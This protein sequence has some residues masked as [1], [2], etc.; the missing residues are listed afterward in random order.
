MSPHGYE[1]VEHTADLALHVWGEEFYSLLDHSAQ[2]MY[3]L[4]GITMNHKFPAEWTFKIEEGPKECM[5]VDF[6]S[7]VLYLCVD[8][9]CIFN[10]F[11]FSKFDG[12]LQIN[13]TGF[14]MESMK[15][16]IKAVTFH[17]LEFKETEFGLETT[18]VF[19]V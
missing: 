8:K 16:M 11:I 7:E 10:E 17:N 6:L 5:L 2:G 4:L 19:D 13:A 15:R 14:R 1:E 12:N 9:K 18:I 3:H